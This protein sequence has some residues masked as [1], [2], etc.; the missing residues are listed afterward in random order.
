MREEL[1]E[2]DR[3]T[4]EMAQSAL[5]AAKERS[6]AKDGKETDPAAKSTREA[7]DQA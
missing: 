2:I 4:T 1:R 5:K 3:V 7:G 6:A